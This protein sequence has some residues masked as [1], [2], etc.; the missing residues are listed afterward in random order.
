MLYLICW[1]LKGKI[2]GNEITTRKYMKA[3]NPNKEDSSSSEE[4]SV[5]EKRQKY[6]RGEK[7]IKKEGNREKVMIPAQKMEAKKRP[8]YFAANFIPILRQK[9]VG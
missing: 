6:T 4:T 3:K 7:K 5:K 9:K 2:N 1:G 8:A